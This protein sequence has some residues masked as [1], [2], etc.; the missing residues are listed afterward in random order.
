MV[1]WIDTHTHF[2]MLE[3]G[4]E[5][6]LEKAKS[7]GVQKF[8]NIGTNPEDHEQVYDFAQ[9]HYPTVFCT[10]GVHPHD[11]KIYTD[12]VDKYLR[13]KSQNKEVIAIGEIGLDYYYLNST[14]E[15]Q[16]AA[17]ERQLQVAADLGLPVEIHTR[18]AEEDTIEILKKY[19][20][21]VKGLLHCFTGTQ[22]LADEALKIGFN[23]SISGVV[24]F[25]NAEDLRSI[26]KSLP[27]D[28]IHVETDAPFLAPVPQR[29]KK[30]TPAFVTHVG[31]FV[32][33]LK[34]VTPEELSAQILKNT[35]TLFPKFI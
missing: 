29:G 6:G 15:E 12:E 10:L 22:W 19:Q 14:K 23:I 2:G 25:K 9:K 16:K 34:G 5:A 20:G 17:F 31:E 4:A 1:Q 24:T 11:A 3:E 27:L 32:A 21:K 18:D 33:G 35:K 8:I 7:L 26:V 13:L 30:N 28:R